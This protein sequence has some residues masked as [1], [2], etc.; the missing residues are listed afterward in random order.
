M[1]T[2]FWNSEGVVLGFLEKVAPVTQKVIL[3]P[4]KFSKNI[5]K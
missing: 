2:L 3:K 5:S 1:L 4:K